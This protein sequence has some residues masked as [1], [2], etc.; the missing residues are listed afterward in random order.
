MTKKKKLLGQGHF[1]CK[2]INGEDVRVGDF[3]KVTRP[4][5]NIG[6]SGGFEF[7]E[8]DWTG[9]VRLLLSMGLVVKTG[10]SYVKPPRTQSSINKWTWE[11]IDTLI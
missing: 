10:N 4:D 9:Q 2:D 6:G 7:E 1:V 8:R 3:V 5:F 11:L